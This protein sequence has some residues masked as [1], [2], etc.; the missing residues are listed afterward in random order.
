MSALI[1]LLL[2]VLIAASALCS[3]MEI[4][5]L[6]VSPNRVRALARQGA[7]KA[8]EVA[9]KLSDL[10]RV[11]N[12]LLIANNIVNISISTVSTAL[13]AALF[14]SSAAAEAA[15]S[16]A[17]AVTVLFLG[18]YLPKLIFSASPTQ[19]LFNCIAFYHFLE[20][21]LRPLVSVFSFFIRFIFGGVKASSPR[22]SVSRDGL[23]RLV[24]DTDNGTMLT[25]FE[26]RLIDRVL[27]LQTLTAGGMVHAFD[28]ARPHP[29][30]RIASNVRGDDILPLMR[31]AHRAEATVFDAQT[32]ADIGVVTEEDVLVALTGVLKE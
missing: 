31:K 2:V 24:A 8:A 32:G 11:V 21:T 10:P 5:F 27:M 15:W 16:F 19:R 30:L 13:A 17:V 12:T 6:S 26:R 20:V 7:A 25:T 22:Q 29:T 28:P 4:G 3:G 18:E 23:R 1:A 9:K 14:S